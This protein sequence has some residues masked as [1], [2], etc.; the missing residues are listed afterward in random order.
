[1]SKDKRDLG[2]SL[3]SVGDRYVSHNP[4]NLHAVKAELER[5]RRRR[6]LFFGGQTVAAM[7]VI[8]VLAVN[9]VPRLASDD[10]LPDPVTSPPVVQQLEVAVEVPIDAPEQVSSSAGQG[11]F[12]TQPELSSISRVDLET[13]R[14]KWTQRLDGPPSDIVSASN[15]LWVTVPSSGTIYHRDAR[16]GLDASP[17]IRLSDGR[18]PTRLH[19]TARALRVSLESGGALKIDISSRDETPLFT[20]DLIDIASGERYFWVFTTEG[21][22]QAVD[23][24]NGAPIAAIAPIEAPTNGEIT[25]AR[26]AIWYGSFEDNLLLRIDE[27]T[28]ATTEARLPGDYLDLEADDEG[29]WVLVGTG[30]G[31]GEVIEID[32]SDGSPGDRSVTLEGGPSDLGLRG[33][34]LWVVL[35]DAESVVNVSY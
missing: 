7:A 10:R 21:S 6:R 19:V 26:G 18:A 12:I 29:L 17:P 24:D 33:Q 5:R 4:S 3:K 1:M 31:S 30:D 23:S 32:P 22:I 2:A 13:G 25:F 28:G 14:I 11:A 27:A 15:G 35:R 16:T 34:G 8:A 9:F 20:G